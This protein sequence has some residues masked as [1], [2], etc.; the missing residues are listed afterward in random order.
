MLG[1]SLA[2][3]L[4]TIKVRIQTRPGAYRGMLHCAST[5]VRAEGLLALYRGLLSP[6]VGYGLINATAFGSYNYGK[7]LLRDSHIWNGKPGEL[8]APSSDS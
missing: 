8:Y 4:D 2:Y 3:P 1:L 6:V 7:Q 5:L